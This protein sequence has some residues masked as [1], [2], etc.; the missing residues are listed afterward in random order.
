MRTNYLGHLA[1]IIGIQWSTVALL[2]GG[3]KFNSGNSRL[4][5]LTYCKRQK[6]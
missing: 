4:N 3:G 5:W 2:G 1:N 6:V